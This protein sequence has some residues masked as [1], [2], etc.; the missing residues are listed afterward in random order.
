MTLAVEHDVKP[1]QLTGTKKIK[2]D[3]AIKVG[4]PVPRPGIGV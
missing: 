3:G 4:T 2:Q 1:Q